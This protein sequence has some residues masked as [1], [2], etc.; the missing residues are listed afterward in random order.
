M[1]GTI[2]A[3]YHGGSTGRTRPA[4]AGRDKCETNGRPVGGQREVRV[5]VSP[6]AKPQTGPQEVR[7][8]RALE[9]REEVDRG[10]GLGGAREGGAGDQHSD[11]P[12][13]TTADRNEARRPSRRH[14]GLGGQIMQ[15]HR[16]KPTVVMSSWWIAGT[17]GL[18]GGMVLMLAVGL[19]TGITQFGTPTSQNS[20]SIHQGAGAAQN[21]PVVL[22]V[23]GRAADTQASTG[24]STGSF[25][26]SAGSSAR[27]LTRY[28]EA[29]DVINPWAASKTPTGGGSPK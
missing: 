13:V 11:S 6:R 22:P 26:A 2:P 10:G 17:I 20:T 23:S 16:M 8:G 4:G 1:K 25:S 29:R 18:V 9:G 21:N 28:Q 24:A 19:A 27:P 15:A 3:S 14:F 12:H 7:D 5:V